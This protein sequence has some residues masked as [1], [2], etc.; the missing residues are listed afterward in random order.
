[1]LLATSPPPASP[2]RVGTVLRISAWLLDAI[3]WRRASPSVVTASGVLNAARPRLVPVIMITSSAWATSCGAVGGD[4]FSVWVGVGGVSGGATGFCA[5]AGLAMSTAAVD[6]RIRR[7]RDAIAMDPLLA[8]GAYLGTA[9]PPP[10]LT[11]SRGG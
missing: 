10:L 5:T 4:W 11:C 7:E 3:F 1:M 6:S 9:A 2:F 8:I